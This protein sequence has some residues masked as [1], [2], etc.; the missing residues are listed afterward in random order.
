MEERKGGGNSRVEEW[1]GGEG[2][3]DCAVLKDYLKSQGA[4]LILRHIDNHGLL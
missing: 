1:W 3:T 2:G 4:P